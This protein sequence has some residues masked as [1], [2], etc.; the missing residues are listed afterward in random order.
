MDNMLGDLYK[1][2][3]G[4]DFYSK[5]YRDE[6]ENVSFQLLEEITDGFSES[7]ELGRGS[8]GVVYRVS[9][10]LLAC[11]ISFNKRSYVRSDQHTGLLP[12]IR[13]HMILPHCHKY[14]ICI[15]LVFSV[16]KM[17]SSHYIH[18]K[19]EVNV[20]LVLTTYP[21]QGLTKNGDYVAVKK[22]HAN[23]T[24]LNHKQFQ[25]E[26]YN[27]A[28]LKHENIVR[29]YGYCYET[30]KTFMEHDRRKILVEEPHIALCLE[31]LH[32]GSLQDHISG[33]LLGH[34]N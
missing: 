20:C 9:M 8:F 33:M 5:K 4:D 21:Q 32:N 24:D 28:K 27:L 17:I 19:V 2:D 1:P 11:M 10:I 34:L 14:S 22:L 18:R 3:D 29:I 7:R 6:L 13:I 31:Y 30:K 25:N 26:L 16:I 23:V 12:I 15:F